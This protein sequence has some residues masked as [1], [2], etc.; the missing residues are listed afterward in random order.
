MP[1]IGQE[2]SYLN[3]ELLPLK[4]W[5]DTMGHNDYTVVGYADVGGQC[6]NDENF[7][8]R[9]ISTADHHYNPKFRSMFGSIEGEE[10]KSMGFVILDIFFP[11][12]PVLQRSKEGKI[13]CVESEFQVISHSYSNFLIG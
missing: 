9:V 6:L 11:N 2:V 7:L 5:I 3:C 10:L 4:V 8:Q 12:T 13:L 1:T